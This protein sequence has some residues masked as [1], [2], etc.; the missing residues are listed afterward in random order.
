MCMVHQCD[1]RW[2]GAVV[3]KRTSH[4]IES[5]TVT[6]SLTDEDNSLLKHVQICDSATF[7][8]VLPVDYFIFGSHCRP[9]IDAQLK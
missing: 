1:I 4:S 5:R 6:L 7:A 8:R 3:Y 2:N 9:V